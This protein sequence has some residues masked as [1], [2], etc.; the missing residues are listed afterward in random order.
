[1]RV[2]NLRVDRSIK[3]MELSHKKINTG[4]NKKVKQNNE[5]EKA[6]R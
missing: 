5:S 3:Y 1:M 4:E 6:E 2:E